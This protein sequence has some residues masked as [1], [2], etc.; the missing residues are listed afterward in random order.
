[1]LQ[2]ILTGLNGLWRR[3]QELQSLKQ[4]TAPISV[5]QSIQ[6]K[7]SILPDYDFASGSGAV[8]GTSVSGVVGAAMTC[9][10]AGAAGGIIVFLKRRNGHKRQ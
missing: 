10:L 8:N 3:L 5:A 2:L 9:V 7:T 1:M 4:L 6:E